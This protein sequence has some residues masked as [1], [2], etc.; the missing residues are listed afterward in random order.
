VVALSLNLTSRTITSGISVSAALKYPSVL[1]TRVLE[2]HTAHYGEMRYLGSAKVHTGNRLQ[3]LTIEGEA[4][5]T[6][7]RCIRLKPVQSVWSRSQ[8]NSAP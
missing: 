6:K 1:R 3:R 5:C 2:S 4:V 8:R 7:W